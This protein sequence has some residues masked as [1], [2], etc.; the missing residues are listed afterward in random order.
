LAVVVGAVS[1]A[2]VAVAWV[3]GVMFMAM[4]SWKLT[5]HTVYTVDPKLTSRTLRAWRRRQTEG[6]KIQLPA[7]ACT[8]AQSHSD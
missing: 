4:H 6:S 1:A 3:L 8:Q 7:R 5:V 2:G